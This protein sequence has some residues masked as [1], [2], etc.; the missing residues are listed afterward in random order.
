[1]TAT[2]FVNSSHLSP[3]LLVIRDSF[4]AQQTKTLPS[5]G[6]ELGPRNGQNH[7]GG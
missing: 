5:R 2:L 4:K 6:N 7:Y 3:I 1:M